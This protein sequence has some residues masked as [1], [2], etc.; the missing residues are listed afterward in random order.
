VKHLQEK[1]IKPSSN[2]QFN[3]H[4]PDGHLFIV[5]GGKGDLPISKVA[6]NVKNIDESK[7]ESW[8]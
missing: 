3:L 4:D 5:S 6:L 2:G 8:R 1:G 7:G